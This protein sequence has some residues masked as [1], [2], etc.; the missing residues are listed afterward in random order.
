MRTISE[1]LHGRLATEGV[2]PAFGCELADQALGM[3]GDAQ[4]DVLQIVERGHVDELTALDERI[5]QCGAT[6]PL[7]AACAATM[8]SAARVAS[9]RNVTSE[10]PVTCKAD[11]FIGMRIKTEPIFSGR[12]CSEVRAP[13]LR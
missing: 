4:E 3:S 7:E 11:R 12:R 2:G 8:R 5:E 1:D 10:T 13:E 6:G 9:F